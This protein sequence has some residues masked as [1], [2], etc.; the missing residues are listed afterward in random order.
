MKHSLDK[1]L[2]GGSHSES[3]GQWLN[4]QVEAGDEWH[5]SGINVETNVI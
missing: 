2:A 3:C 4:V 5:S 1:G